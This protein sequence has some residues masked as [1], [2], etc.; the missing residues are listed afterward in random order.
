MFTGFVIEPQIE[1]IG[2]VPLDKGRI[3]AEP[4]HVS[5]GT[6]AS[7]KRVPYI[8]RLRDCHRYVVSLIKNSL[9]VIVPEGCDVRNG[10]I[11][12]W[13][14]DDLRTAPR[15]ALVELSRST[16]CREVHITCRKGYV[17]PHES[18]IRKFI[19]GGV[20]D[21]NRGLVRRSIG[22]DPVIG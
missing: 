8:E 5:P 15:G 7:H 22:E 20:V 19:P 17:L 11:P 18:D 13:E 1:G 4:G 2:P 3:I 10:I 12:L 16:I 9:K 14:G 21:L 6:Q